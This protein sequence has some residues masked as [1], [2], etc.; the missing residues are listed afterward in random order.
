MLI[1]IGSGYRRGTRAVRLT[2]RRSLQLR[3]LTTTLLL[4]VLVVTVVGSLLLSRITDGLVESRR[5]SVENESAL[6]FTDADQFVSS[7]QATGTTGQLA[8]DLVNRLAGPVSDP[9]RIVILLPTTTDGEQSSI[10]GR[11]SSGLSG[12]E[13]G[14]IIPQELRDRVAADP[15]HQQSANVALPV[16]GS[17][18]ER[19]IVPAVAVG[20]QVQLGRSAGGTYDLYLLYPLER[21][22][23]VL[24]LIQRVFWIGGVL[25]VVLV[26]VVAYVVTR[27]VVAPVRQAAITA[28]TLASGHL[29]RRM[30]VRGEDD[31]ARLGRAFNEMAASLERQIHQLEDLSLAQRR[32]VSDVS[33]ELRTPLTTIRMAGEVIHEARSEFD[34]ALARSAE[35]LHTQ[36]DRFETLLADLLEIS[37]FDAGAA[38][39]ENESLDVGEIVGR[40]VDGLGPLADRGASPII[41]QP[42][43]VPCVAEC[44]PRRVERIVRNLVANAID[45]G[46]GGAVTVSV[47]A[48]PT[49]VAVVVR[50]EGVGLGSDELPQVFD[51]F[52]RADPARARNTGGT[53]LGLSIAKEDALLH[54]GW[55][56]VW[57][58]P[59]LGAS[60]RLTL[61]RRSGIVLSGS[62]LPLHPVD[63]GPE[64]GGAF[65]EG[66][67][68]HV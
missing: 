31:L 39:L 49:A 38:R 64:D 33:H 15:G 34:P 50:D 54:G 46:E 36:L 30:K 51:R 62:P 2:W 52:W 42:S 59:G 67:E 53:G 29:D 4:G 8:S 65:S 41:Y 12:G 66:R 45:H 23:Q 48:D 57:S 60:F 16:S 14:S 37:R 11:S 32:F 7:Y 18:Q 35:L 3:V 22:V 25:L 1:R 10:S 44:D 28:E 68:S 6:V 9:L 13:I 20:T 56:Q 19:R 17:G 63:V 5:V 27:Q 40:V 43:P 55:L 26:G 47:A 24:D 61:P 58:R 21:E